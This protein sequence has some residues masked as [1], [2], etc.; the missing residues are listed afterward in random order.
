MGQLQELG[1]GRREIV[2]DDRDK[3]MVKTTHPRVARLTT[4]P[5]ADGFI[6]SDGRSLLL[7]NLSATIQMSLP[8]SLKAKAKKS[9]RRLEF[10]W[11]V[12]EEAEIGVIFAAVRQAA[13]VAAG[14]E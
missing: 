1:L 11:G 7:R 5:D 9:T 10:S 8:G 13:G 3:F 12:L 4:Q 14:H 2:S 6:R